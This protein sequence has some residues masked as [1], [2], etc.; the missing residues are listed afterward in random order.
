[1]SK[2]RFRYVIAYD[3]PGDRR[4]NKIAR[5]LEGHGERVQYS[6]FECLLMNE[7]FDALWEELG[8]LVDLEQDSLRAYRLCA[9]CDGWTRM[10]GEA[11]MA[12]VPEVY[13]A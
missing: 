5:A 12:E 7:Q 3:V 8:N 4:R 11:K 2:H 6:V 1:M 13:I 9:A 10:L